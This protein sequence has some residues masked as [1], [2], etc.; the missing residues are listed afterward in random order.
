MRF[1]TDNFFKQ[2]DI[3]T[4]PKYETAIE[5]EILIHNQQ[6][7]LEASLQT[8]AR[9]VL[10]ANADLVA[11]RETGFSLEPGYYGHLLLDRGLKK[12]RFFGKPFPE[13]YQL[14]EKSLPKFEVHKI[15]MCGD[16]LHTD[17]IGAT[18]RD[19][20]TVLVTQD[21]MFSGHDAL[22]FCHEAGIFADWRVNRI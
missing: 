12:V 11:P 4:N 20:R 15:I 14:V 22:S 6:K 18:A 7:T 8:R 3:I 9:P 5:E 1:G 17:I 21:G 19:W 16:T 2:T 10:V 13:V